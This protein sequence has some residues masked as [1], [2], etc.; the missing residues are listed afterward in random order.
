MDEGFLQ[1][2]SYYNT[3]DF[4]K[5]NTSLLVFIVVIVIV[6]LLA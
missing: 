2:F 6:C 4:R 1:R 5:T 3:S